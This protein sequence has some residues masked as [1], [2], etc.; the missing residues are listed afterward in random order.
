[1]VRLLGCAL[2]KAAGALCNDEG[3]RSKRD[4]PTSSRSSPNARPG[5]ACSTFFSAL[6]PTPTCSTACPTPRRARAAPPAAAPRA[7]PP[8]PR[9]RPPGAPRSPPAETAP[10][11][12][13]SRMRNAFSEWHAHSSSAA[14]AASSCARRAASTT[15]ENSGRER[16]PVPSASAAR[17]SASIE[18]TTPGGGPSKPGARIRRPRGQEE[19][20][21]YTCRAGDA[22]ISD[23]GVHQFRRAGGRRTRTATAMADEDSH[24]PLLATRATARVESR[25]LD[26]RSTTLI[27]VGCLAVMAWSKLSQPRSPPPPPPLRWRNSNFHR[28]RRPPRPPPP[29]RRPRTPPPPRRRRRRRRS[30]HRRA[31]AVRVARR[32]AAVRARGARRGVGARSAGLRRAAGADDVPAVGLALA[33]VDG[34]DGARV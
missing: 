10:E 5:A 18:C 27:I 23:K 17:T 4:S 24:Q 22:R 19:R 12:S 31:D 14:S 9:R 8:R 21:A 33:R 3:N 25:A 32:D 30:H 7:R 28:R 15:A 1:M 29:P 6:R 11:S 13:P 34:R 16:S 20:P 26:V 2:E